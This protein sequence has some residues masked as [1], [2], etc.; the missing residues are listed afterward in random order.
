MQFHYC[1]VIS[2]ITVTREPE[3]TTLFYFYYYLFLSAASG[4]TADSR[5]AIAAGA[6]RFRICFLP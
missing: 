6:R 5:P 3:Q 1:T 2:V 4:V